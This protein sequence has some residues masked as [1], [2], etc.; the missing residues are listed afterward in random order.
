MASSSTTTAMDRPEQRESLLQKAR[1]P[2][3]PL[4][5]FGS[6]TSKMYEDVPTELPSLVSAPKT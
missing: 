5:S 1:K 3:A 4:R 6:T 2:G